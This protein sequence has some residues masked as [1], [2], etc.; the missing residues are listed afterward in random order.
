MPLDLRL[1]RRGAHQERNSL[2]DVLLIGSL[3]NAIR[4]INYTIDESEMDDAIKQLKH[5]DFPDLVENN[6]KFRRILTEVIKISYYKDGEGR[7]RIV[8]LMDFE[9]PENNDFLALNCLPPIETR[10]RSYYWFL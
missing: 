3:K 6:E 10:W 2:A 5:L 7:G 4:R 8:W 9:H 1:H